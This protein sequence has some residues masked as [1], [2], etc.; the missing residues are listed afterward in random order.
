MLQDQT[1]ASGEL[2]AVLHAN[3]QQTAETERI[4]HRLT[5]TWGEPAVL[6][7]GWQSSAIKDSSLTTG[8][9]TMLAAVPDSVAMNRVAAAGRIAE[10]ARIGRLNPAQMVTELRSVRNLP[11]ASDTAFAL[12]SAIGAAALALSFGALHWLTLLVVSLSAG[13]GAVL[14]RRIGRAGGSA[15]LQVFLAA[16]LAGIIGAICVRLGVSSDLRLMA[17]CPCMVMVPGP[18]LLNG[19]LDLLDNRLPL[20]ASRLLFATLTLSAIAAGLLCGLL[21]LNVTLP[22]APP[23][24]DVPLAI[25]VIAGGVAAACYSTFFSLPRH[26]LGWPVFAA[27]LADAARWAAMTILH[28]SPAGGAAVAGLIAGLL[29]VPV[30]RRWHVPFAGIGFAAIVSLMPGVFVF[31]MAAG[32]IALSSAPTTSVPNLIEAVALDGLTAALII[33]TLTLGIIIPKLFYD[34]LARH[35]GVSA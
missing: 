21:A 26:L 15:F 1:D 5:R 4:L 23:G 3:G 12:A 8:T 28:L 16:L 20:G 31:R 30:S 14:R 6:L 9:V 11:L 33:A 7:P 22:P 17:V 24:R 27:M 13:C 32:I 35:W 19:A 18:H 25:V 29:L 34:A 2:V 10:A